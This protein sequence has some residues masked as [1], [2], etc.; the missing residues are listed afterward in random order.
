MSEQQPVITQT[1]TFHGA[2]SMAEA[3]VRGLIGRSVMLPRDIYML[4]RSNASRLDELKQ[5]YQVNVSNEP[6]HKNEILSS[7]PIIVLAMKPKDAVSA[8]KELGPL[9]SEHQMVISV[10]AGLSI[11]TMQTLLGRNQ[12]VVRTM[13][14]TSSSIGFGSTGIAFSKEITEEQRQTVMTLFE[15]IGKVTMIQE[16][17]MEILTGIS[18]SGPA[19]VYYMMES[20]IAAGIRGGLTAEQ[21]KELTFQTFTGAARM[22]QQTGEE[23]SSLRKKIM[24][25]N[26]TTQ[27][28]LERLDEGDFFETVIAAVN[29]CAERSRELTAS[30]E[31]GIK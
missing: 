3:I 27:A 29:R 24:S 20:M 22:V 15:A 30:L 7:S 13:P 6:A 17:K 16:D 12:P 8:L 5:K 31:E 18:G 21:S 23:P 4:N 14:N 9:L 19:Y 10:I 1:I 28:A 25:P 2:G 11:R 26:G